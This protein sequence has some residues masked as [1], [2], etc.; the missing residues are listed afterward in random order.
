MN[1]IFFGS[2][3][4]YSVQVLKVLSQHFHVTAVGTTPPKPQGRHL[5]VSPTPVEAF[6]RNHDMQVFALN[7]LETI[8]SGMPQPDFFVVAGYGKRIPA[9]WLTFPNIM[10][11][12]VHPSL[13]PD[14]RG[15]FPAEW[16]IL[17][18]EKET[19]VTILRMSPEFD[20]GDIIA[21]TSLPI[22]PDDTRETLYTKL[23]DLGGKLLVDYLPKI[24]RGTVTLTRQ[25]AGKFFYARRLTREDGYEPWETLTDPKEAKRLNRKFRALYPWPGLWT[26]HKG[27]RLKILGYD[28]TP[29]IVQMEGKKPMSWKQWNTAYLAS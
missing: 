6:A 5:T 7:Q 18:G 24:A 17:R 19:G 2:F 8:P 12:N 28:V 14:Y 25:P 4:T 9:S 22:T 20:T 23:Y 21:Q 1:I 27:K 29:T 3:Q 10:A 16:V 11:V 26:T 13:L 15:V